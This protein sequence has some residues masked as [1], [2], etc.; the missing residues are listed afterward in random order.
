M[1]NKRGIILAGVLLALL[2]G[3]VYWYFS[4]KKGREHFNWKETFKADSEQPYGSKFLYKLLEKQHG[5]IIT[6]NKP[7]REFLKDTNKYRSGYNYIFLGGSM[8]VNRED[9]EALAAFIARGNNVIVASHY[10]PER[11]VY[12]AYEGSC[13]EYYT[14]Y[15]YFD[16]VVRVNFYHPSLRT[17]SG[18]TFSV[19]MHNQKQMYNWYC[20]NGSLFCGKQGS[21]VAAGF[22]NEGYAN[23]AY[24]QHGAGRLYLHTS[25]V[26]FT[27]F[28]LKDTTGL[29]YAEGVFS[30]LLPGKIIWDEYSQLPK[31]QNNNRDKNKDSTPLSYIL[32]QPG[33]RYA[34]YML[35]L[36]ALLY[37]I[38]V[39]RRR[40]RVIEVQEPN[41]NTSLSYISTIS[42]LYFFQKNHGA[43]AQ[44][45]MKFFLTFVR[46]RYN[47]AA[48][49]WQPAD[50][51]R[52]AKKSKVPVSEIES[53]FKLH[54]WISR[55]HG[56]ADETLMEFHHTL[57]NFYNKCN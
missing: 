41:V 40:Q 25:P 43:V 50:I 24:L 15:D 31:F 22:M 21:F 56:I 38:F 5:P 42:N 12:Q 57:Q 2:L 53:I 32:S 34:W 3:G 1:N 17:D 28:F 47:I 55:S 8:Y 51:E 11:L 33:L 13:G 44:H 49:E 9:A 46:N 45:K 19:S 27:N 52:L 54:A 14:Y 30:H 37:L 23:F 10:V 7:L 36:G 6:V 29:R 18:Y 20:L 39:A 35:L 48:K 16:S 26:L 4:G